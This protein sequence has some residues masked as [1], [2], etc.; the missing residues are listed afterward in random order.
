MEKIDTDESQDEPWEEQ[1]VAIELVGM[2]DPDKLNMV[3]ASNTAV[4]VIQGFPKNVSKR[5]IPNCL[6]SL[7]GKKRNTLSNR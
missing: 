5:K 7:S 3:N 1:L 6:Y 4:L 2:I